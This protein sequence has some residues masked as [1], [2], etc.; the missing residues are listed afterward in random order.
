MSTVKASPDRTRSI[1]YVVAGAVSGVL[2]PLLG[3][4]VCAILAFAAKDRATRVVLIV[5]AVAWLLFATIFTT[6]LGSSS[7]VTTGS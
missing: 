2:W 3:V 5:L 7:G 6:F 1:L 4:A